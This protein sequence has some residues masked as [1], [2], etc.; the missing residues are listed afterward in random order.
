VAL[1]PGSVVWPPLML[2]RLQASKPGARVLVLPVWRDSVEPGEP[3]G[4]WR[5]R[6]LAIG[7][8][9]PGATRHEGFVRCDELFA[10]GQLLATRTF[11]DDRT[12]V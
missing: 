3:G 2:L 7:R 4:R 6:V 12:R 10:A 11:S 8:R 5:S 9:G 1:L